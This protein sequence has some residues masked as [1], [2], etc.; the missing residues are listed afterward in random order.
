MIRLLSDALLVFLCLGS[1]VW[2]FV[3]H[4][5]T[6]DPVHLTHALLMLILA[7]QFISSLDKSLEKERKKLGID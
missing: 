7:G 6:D 2:A 5:K 3:L 1:S 4:Y